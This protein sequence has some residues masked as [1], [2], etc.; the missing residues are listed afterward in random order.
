MKSLPVLLLF[1][2]FSFSAS[3]TLPGVGNFH[4][5][6][7]HVYRG[8]QP[9]LDGL[10]NLA[11]LGV[12]IIVDLREAGDR[13]LEEEKSVAAQGMSYFAV[14]MNGLHAPS[15]ETVLKVLDVLEDSAKGPVF[16]H[17]KRG[18][19]RTGTIIAS[20]RIEHDHWENQ[21]ALEEA[22]AF[23]MSRLEKGMQQY[24]LHYQPRS[25]AVASTGQAQIMAPLALA[26]P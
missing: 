5:V 22:K 6:D 23:G 25:L 26:K 21:K 9:S 1:S 3:F 13:S 10:R 20:Y 16:V 18:A 7:D 17:C 4:Q 15:A 11:K 2:S 12:K 19:D 24:I 14:P 8:A